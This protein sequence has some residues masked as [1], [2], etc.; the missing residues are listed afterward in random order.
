M[1]DTALHIEGLDVRFHNDGRIVQAVA[2]VSLTIEAGRTLAV[3]GESGSGKSVTGLS[4]VRLLGRTAARVH[5]GR[6]TWRGRDLLR[7]PEP[8]MA[9]IRGRE[10]AMVFQDPGSS[11]NPTF[12]VGE[13]VAETIRLDG[14]TGRVKANAQAID[15]LRSVGISDPAN[16]MRAYPHQMSGGMRQRVMIAIA[17]A[18]NPQMLIADE[19]TTA[20]DVTVQRQVIDLLRTA[21]RERGMGMMFVTHDLRLAEEIADRVAVMYAGQVVEDGPMDAVLA[22][23]RHPYTRALL[24]CV[25]R[26]R[27]Q[28]RLRPVGGTMPDPQAP[29]PGCRFHPRCAHALP[30]CTAAPPPPEPAGAGRETRCIRWREVT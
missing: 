26:G 4:V 3:V 10:I 20:L 27:A 11:L 24:D 28:G 16:R 6:I 13:Q 21:Q 9:R 15:L 12:T 2:G 23:P 8:D 1:S 14:K 19:P 5:G 17:L 18:R 22:R 30:E 25:P 7:L 29:P